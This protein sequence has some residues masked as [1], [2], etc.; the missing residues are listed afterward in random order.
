MSRDV[1]T[2]DTAIAH[3]PRIWNYWL[4]G[5]DN[6]AIDRKVGD[7]FRAIYPPIVDVARSSR[8]FL[9][10]A[11]RH[12]AGPVGIRQF[13]DVGT[14][15]PTTENTHEIVQ[16][17]APDA[18]VVYVDNDPV[19][20]AHARVLMHSDSGNSIAYVD[21]DLREPAG[22]L[23]AV[24]SILAFDR[25]VA[26]VLAN[27]L[28]HIPDFADVRRIVAEFV[29]ALAPGSYLVVADATTD[30][31][32][33][34]AAVAMWNQAGSLPYVLRT[35]EQIT[36]LFDGLELVEPGVVPCSLWRPYGS[37][38]GQVAAADVVGA[39]GRRP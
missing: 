3:S 25:P 23:G 29:S 8:D 11:M 4:G 21:G 6:Y 1:P 7:V 19:V 10:R 31:G 27:V 35:P 16:R 30:G 28:G 18:R 5:K 38:T 39:V 20:L 37:Q 32:S 9:G 15:L 36:Q 12:L 33:F 17:I 26:L 2:S 34:D 24:A 22:I 14:G 13:L